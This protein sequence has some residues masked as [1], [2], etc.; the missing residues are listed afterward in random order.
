MPACEGLETR[1]TCAHP[2]SH[3]AVSEESRI[4][5][6]DSAVQELCQ[7]Q[8][9]RVR[10]LEGLS[11]EARERR[12]LAHTHMPRHRAHLQQHAAPH[13]HRI[14]CAQQLLRQC[15]YF[16]TSKAS[17]LSTCAQLQRLLEPQ[18]ERTH[19][20][21]SAV[22]ICTFVLV[23]H[24]FCTSEASK[25]STCSTSYHQRRAV[26]RRRL[27]GGATRDD[28]V[29][30]E[31]RYRLRARFGGLLQHRVRSACVAL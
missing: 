12:A 2:R 9:L 20:S 1:R 14:A 10:L 25:L 22:I 28:Y 7:Q 11:V 23:K 29:A 8:Q 24:L 18:L 4:R 26:R 13:L 31:G 17:N 15:L 19:C 27:G 3:L 16:C 30:Q 5:R 21:S 6:Q